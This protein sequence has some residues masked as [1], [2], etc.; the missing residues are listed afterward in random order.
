LLWRSSGASLRR[1]EAVPDG[2]ARRRNAADRGLAGNC[3]FGAHRQ[4]QQLDRLPAV[5]FAGAIDR[6]DQL[7][8]LHR[9]LK[10]E[11][12]RVLTAGGSGEVLRLQPVLLG[13]GK[14][15]HLRLPV[16]AIM[17]GDTVMVVAAGVERGSDLDEAGI[18]VE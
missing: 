9:I 17:Q 8:V 6:V 5:L 15:E 10:R 1:V 16:I 18:A 4:G 11:D 12:R 2:R 7:L 3:R 14:A 13:S